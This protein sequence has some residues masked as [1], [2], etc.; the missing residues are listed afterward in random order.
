MPLQRPLANVAN[1]TGLKLSV[2]A[3]WAGELCCGGMA[4]DGGLVPRHPLHGHGSHAAR[5]C[6]LCPVRM[7]RTLHDTACRFSSPAL[8][9]LRTACSN[10]LFSLRIILYFFT[11]YLHNTSGSLVSPNHKVAMHASSGLM[12]GCVVRCASSWCVSLWVGRSRRHARAAPS[13]FF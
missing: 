2:E 11:Y 3:Q 9:S 1:L 13:L 6:S 4:L 7:A 8:L 10:L 12:A 5:L